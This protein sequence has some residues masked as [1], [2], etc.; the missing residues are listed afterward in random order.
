[1]KTTLWLASLILLISGCT[2]SAEY[3]PRNGDIIFQTSESAQSTAIQLATHSPY[4]H[5][6]IVYVDNGQAIARVRPGLEQGLLV[7]EKP[8]VK[9]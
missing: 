6:G 2:H 4:S 3:Q 7:S 8:L 9:G 5:M 1:M